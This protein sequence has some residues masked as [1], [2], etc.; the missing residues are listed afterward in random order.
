MATLSIALMTSG[1]KELGGTMT[2]STNRASTSYT[3]TINYSWYGRVGTIAT[4]VGDSCTWT[5]SLANLAPL[6]PDGTSGVCTLTCYT[7]ENGKLLGSRDSSITLTVPASA[8]PTISSVSISDSR[9]YEEI[10]GGYVRGMSNLTVN[11]NAAGV[12]GST[13][14]KYTAKVGSGYIS[15]STN[16]TLTPRIPSDDGSS[17]TPSEE[18]LTTSVVDSR[19]RGAYDY[20]TI[21]IYSYYWPSLNGTTIKRWNTTT[22]KEDDES[23]TIRVSVNST[24]WNVA[25]KNI[26][27]AKIEILYRRKG[28]HSEWTTHTTRTNQPV[29]TSFT[30]DM[31]D[32]TE[33]Y[34]Y[35]VKVVLTDSFGQEAVYKYGVST[36]SPVIDLK[37]NGNGVALLGISENDGITF[38]SDSVYFSSQDVN[39]YCR[40]RS[41]NSD[42]IFLGVKGSS[43]MV[44]VYK[45]FRVYGGL[46]QADETF[47]NDRASFNGEALFSRYTLIPGMTIYA[48]DAGLLTSS[49]KKI[50]LTN[51]IS[52]RG[53]NCF[54][55]SSNGIRCTYSG[56]V[57]VSYSVQIYGLTIDR[58]IQAGVDIYKNSVKQSNGAFTSHSYGGVALITCAPMLLS[59]SAGD[60]IYLYARSTD[61]TGFLNR[62][63]LNVSY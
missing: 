33:T 41:N 38:G 18:T 30:V 59:V 47:I 61:G 44:S 63:I 58:N 27:R 9:G 23:S 4:N 42:D 56:Y 62:A 5:P 48:G 12:Y 16:S 49:N 11:I 54:S 37:N 50:P 24:I 40:D 6:I 31:T 15:S 57:K 35:E 25:N 26:N 43:D 17:N 20:K 45:S 60:T 32:M 55:L 51:T 13:I 7:Y 3:H 22:N 34:Q 53:T 2:L 46:F 28:D 1:T 14:S 21:T 19:G 29:S 36:A 52:N 10:Y 39:L 8:K